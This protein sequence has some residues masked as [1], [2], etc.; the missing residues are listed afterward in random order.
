M[1]ET[2]KEP[3]RERWE[4]RARKVEARKR[5][6]TVH[7]AGLKKVILPVILRKAE[8]AERKAK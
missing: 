4:R 7:G 5:R 3:P 2:P 1:S 6:M 8:E